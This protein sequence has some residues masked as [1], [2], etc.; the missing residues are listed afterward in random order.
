MGQQ[1][2]PWRSGDG[3]RL[4]LSTLIDTMER[5]SAADLPHSSGHR[6]VRL[7]VQAQLARPAWPGAHCGSRFSWRN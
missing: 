3:E 6:A 4:W 2:Q 7:A 1:L 5:L